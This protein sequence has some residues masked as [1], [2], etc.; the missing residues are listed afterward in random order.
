MKRSW[1]LLPLLIAALLLS[2]FLWRLGNPPSSVVRSQMVGQLLPDFTVEPALSGQTGFRS[3]DLRGR[4]RL[5]NFFASWCVPCIAEAPMLARLKA[6][7]VE[8]D[9]I[10]VR[11]KPDDLTA[12][13]Q[14]NGNP[15]A[16]IGA[17]PRSAVQLA[18]GSSGVPETFVVDS[19]GVIVDQW[20]APIMAEDVPTILAKLEQAR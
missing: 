14:R 15:Y 3:A 4:P 13:L 6:A 11:D 10:A 7:G 19:R 20:P 8:I 2:A 12:F 16:R 5:V 1:T 17:D 18:M 9:G